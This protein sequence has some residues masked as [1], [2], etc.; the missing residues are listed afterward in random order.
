MSPDKFFVMKI[1]LLALVTGISASA[2]S[3]HA[4]EKGTDPRKQ[5][6]LNFGIG[7]G[8]DYGGIGGNLMV[9]PQR[10]IGLFGG[11]GYALAG[12]GYNGGIK[13]RLLSRQTSVATPSILAMYGYNAAV[14]VTNNSQL[15][16]LFYGPSFGIGVD[17]RSKKPSSEGYLSLAII[18]PVRSPDAQ[19]Y[20]DNLKNLYGATFSNGLLPVTFS[21]GYKFIMNR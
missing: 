19:N 6:I 8:E 21:I 13:L 10:N 9:Y 20:I 1:I 7:I 16:K 14:V 2:L 3:A 15:N 12:F 17:L 4:Q 18:I 11:F 5:D